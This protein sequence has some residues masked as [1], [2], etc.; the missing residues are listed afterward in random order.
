MV[1]QIENSQSGKKGCKIFGLGWKGNGYSPPNYMI[2][3]Y[4]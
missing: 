2:T 3:D 4:P 1:Q